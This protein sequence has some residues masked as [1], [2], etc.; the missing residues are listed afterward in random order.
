MKRLWLSCVVVLVSSACAL[1][2]ELVAGRILAP[3]IGVSLYTWTSVIGIVLAGM[4]A[5]NFAGGLVADRFASRRLLGLTLIA[6]SI[7]SLG[8][9]VVT[10]WVVGDS[11]IVLSLLPRIVFFTTADFFLPVTSCLAWS[12]PSSS[13]WRSS[14]VERSGREVGTIYAC[15]TLGSIFGTFLTGFWLISWIGTRAIVLVVAGVLLLMGVAVGDFVR[16]AK[17]AGALARASAVFAFVLWL[18]SGYRAPCLVES[19]YYLRYRCSRRAPTDIP[20]AR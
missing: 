6:G 15:S 5:G 11:T 3:Y 13:G 8:I 9:L 17:G 18:G 16:S 1:A 19:S 2:I 10:D 20:P 7:A 4:S 14:G 12:R